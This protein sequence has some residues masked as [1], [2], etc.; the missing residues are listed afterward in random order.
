MA[1]EEQKFGIF[2]CYSHTDAAWLKRVQV[3]L[4]PLVRDERIDL[5]DDTRIRAGA[6]WRDEIRK[7]LARARI[8][9]LLISAD[10]FASDFIATKEL[11][12]LLEAERKRGLVILGVHINYSRFDRDEISRIIRPS[13]RLAGRSRISPGLTRRRRSMRSRDAS[14]I[15][16][17]L[18]VERTRLTPDLA[19]S[20][21]RPSPRAASGGSMRSKPWWGRFWRGSRRRCWGRPASARARP[22]CRR[23]TIP[24]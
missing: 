7:A 16:S 24:A 9:V 1:A 21:C 8:A 10:F 23:C 18:R 2:V 22:A 4:K 5:W 19:Q 13:T 14:R 12:P 20:R 11:P 17:L 15:C 3:H 6:H